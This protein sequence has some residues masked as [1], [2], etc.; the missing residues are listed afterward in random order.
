V[1]RLTKGIDYLTFLKDYRGGKSYKEIAISQGCSITTVAN[2]VHSI[3]LKRIRKNRELFSEE[4]KYIFSKMIETHRG[5]EQ[6][7]EILRGK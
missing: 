2:K 6:L 3:G 1:A 7:L 5:R 4:E